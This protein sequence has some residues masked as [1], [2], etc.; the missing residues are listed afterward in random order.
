VLL[1]LASSWL[2]LPLPDQEVQVL[3]LF[4]GEA[5]VARLAKSIGLGVAAHDILFDEEAKRDG[6]K[7]SAMDIN[8]SAGFVFLDLCL[9]LLLHRPGVIKIF[10]NTLWVIW[11]LPRKLL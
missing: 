2:T 6:S 5:R 4:A 3:E 11:A 9:F 10:G 7:R 1:V 8:A